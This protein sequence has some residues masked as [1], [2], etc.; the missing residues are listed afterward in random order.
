MPNHPGRRHAPAGKEAVTWR[1]LHR[2]AGRQAYTLIELLVVIAIIAVLI[3][4]LL[5]AV[6][7]VREAAAHA[8]CRNNLKQIGLAFHNHHTE[9]GFFP[10]GGWEWYTPPTYG[11]NTP[12][13]GDRQQA[14]WGFQI[15]PFVRG[16]NA[17]RGGPLVAIAALNPV[18]FCP[19]RRAPATITYLDE[20]QPPLTG[21]NITHALCDYAASDLEGT[22]V[23][24]QYL[25]VRIGEITDGTS[26]TL[27][28]GDRRLNVAY[29]GGKTG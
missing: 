8:H 1:N 22:G 26:S 25:P 27:M 6:Q 2:D 16:S 21:G 14:G 20:Y 10:T 13:I 15:L 17:W 11:G 19:T 23:V 5:P 28:V 9:Y 4:L 12:L 3:G 24:R 18:F 29:L 7:K